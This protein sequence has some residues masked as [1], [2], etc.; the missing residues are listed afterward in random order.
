MDVPEARSA[1]GKIINGL[2]LNKEDR[3]HLI[4]LICMFSLARLNEQTL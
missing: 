1:L 4:H 3:K 2:S